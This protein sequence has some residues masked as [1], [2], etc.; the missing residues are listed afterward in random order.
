MIFPTWFDSIILLFWLI[1]GAL[2]GAIVGWISSCLIPLKPTNR[3]LDAAMGVSAVLVLCILIVVV[4]RG[5]TTIVDGHTLGRRGWLVDHLFI[6][7][8]GLIGAAVVGRQL[9]VARSRRHV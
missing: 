7:T 9:I 2:L 5:T 6:W 1:G 8:L 3:W 4:T